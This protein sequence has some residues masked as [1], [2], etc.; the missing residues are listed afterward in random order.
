MQGIDVP[1]VDAIDPVT[2][3][4]DRLSVKEL[5][6]THRESI[7]KIKV[8]LDSDPLFD[9]P[10]KHDDLWI[11]RFYLSHKK[12]KPSVK[13]AKHT[14]L[15]RKEHNLDEKSLMSDPSPHLAKDGPLYEYWRDRSPNDSL[16]FSL[17]DKK[18]GV[19]GF[20]KFAG[21][22]PGAS[23]VVSKEAWDYAFIYCS[24]WTH[25]R[26]DY[27]TRTTGLLT[28]SIRLIDMEGVGMKHM[29]RKDAKQDGDIMGLMEDCYPQLLQTI[30]ICNAPMVIHAVWSVFRAI[31]PKRV[32]SKIDIIEPR[33][34]EKERK[35][36]LKYITD[37]NL[38]L[39]FGGKYDGPL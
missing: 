12:V 36:L 13:A 26:L 7:D 35:R 9:Y 6:A 18:R 1:I 27:V 28:K 24:E 3:E 2:P 22:V 32:I 25:Q 33:T 23:S 19:V 8:E 31:M 20:F 30:Y 15:F 14:L 37:D 4:D 11:L 5:I 10:A 34:N 38:P 39:R 17:P 29:N 21:F 16:V